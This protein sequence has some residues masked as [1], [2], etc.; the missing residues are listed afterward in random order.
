MAGVASALVLAVCA[1]HAGG[2]GGAGSAEAPLTVVLR[3]TCNGKVTIIVFQFMNV[4][5]RKMAFIFEGHIQLTHAI[6]AVS[7][8]SWTT[9]A[10]PFSRC[11]HDAIGGIRAISPELIPAEYS[12]PD[13]W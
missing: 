1:L 13:G 9:S 10:R 6:E 7:E 12:L 4:I 3:I 2:L 5:R 11:R 8:V